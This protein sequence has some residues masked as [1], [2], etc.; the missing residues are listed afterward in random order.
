MLSRSSPKDNLTVAQQRNPGCVARVQQL[1][2]HLPQLIDE[3]TWSKT[4][5]GTAEDTERSD[6]GVTAELM[7]IGIRPNVHNSPIL[8]PTN[9]G[10]G[11]IHRSTTA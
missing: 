2:G 7:D 9:G 1:V 6:R 10:T 5:Q 4:N 8:G 3:Q 11:I